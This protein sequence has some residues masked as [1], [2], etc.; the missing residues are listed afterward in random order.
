MG[1]L[2]GYVVIAAILVFLLACLFAPVKNVEGV[3]DFVGDNLVIAL[4]IAGF[5]IVTMLAVGSRGS[6]FI[7]SGGGPVNYDGSRTEI[8]N[9]F[10]QLGGPVENQLPKRIARYLPKKEE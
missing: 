9:N 4:F 2:F 3:L 7:F 1:K 8:N 6:I 5:V 10:L